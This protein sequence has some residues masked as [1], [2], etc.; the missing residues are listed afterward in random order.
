MQITA[1]ALTA[2]ALKLTMPASVFSRSTESHNQDKV[3]MGSIAARDCQRV[4]ELTETVAVVELLA[5]CQ[6]VDLRGRGEL[7]AAQP[8]AARGGARAGRRATTPTAAGRRHRAPC[9]RCSVAASC[10]SGAA[11][12]R[13]DGARA[14]RAL[15]RNRW[16][17]CSR[18]RRRAK[19]VQ[20]GAARPRRE[21]ARRHRRAAGALSK[22][23]GL[24]AR[25]REEKHITM[26][27]APLVSEGTIHFAPP[28][29][30]ARHTEQPIA[31]TLIIDGNQLQFGSADGQESMNLG[32]NPVARL[33]ADGFVML[34]AGNRAGLEQ[35]F[36]MQLT[37]KR[38]RRRR[39]EAGADA[40]RGADGQGDQGAG[41]A[42]ARA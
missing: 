5:L 6:A 10:R 30:F 8:R 12:S 14:V 4:L 32:T 2:E 15:R 24:Y 17:C 38:A 23:P 39:V 31:S 22:A 29:R 37:P 28:S 7:Q 3:S 26:L 18:C 35:I 36:K 34:L 33:F 21:G 13:N 16:R 41:A 27:Q 11:T 19:R 20:R 40:A 1:S 25:F 9:S 42:R